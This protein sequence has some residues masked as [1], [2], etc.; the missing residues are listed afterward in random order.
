L[1]EPLALNAAGFDLD[2]AVFEREDLHRP[3]TE[4]ERYPLAKKE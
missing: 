3:P 1:P 4:W 2:I